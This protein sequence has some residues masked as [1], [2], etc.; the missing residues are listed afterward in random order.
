MTEFSPRARTPGRTHSAA[1]ADPQ[2]Q[3]RIFFP[4]RRRVSF[5]CAFRQ[6]RRQ[7]RTGHIIELLSHHA[8]L[9]R[10]LQ[11]PAN[12]A[13][14]DASTYLENLCLLIS[15]SKLVGMRIDLVLTASPASI[16]R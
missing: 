3:Q 2:D 13:H 16:T 11:M 7:S 5:R 8:E 9:H 4:H 15:R 6:S 14:I 12:D 1:R 10:A